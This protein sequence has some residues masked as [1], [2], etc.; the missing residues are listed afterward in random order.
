MD[1]GSTG[2]ILSAIR[3]LFRKSDTPLEECLRDA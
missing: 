2:K 1:D 3:N